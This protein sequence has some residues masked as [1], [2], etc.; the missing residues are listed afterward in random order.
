MAHVHAWDR[1]A[2]GV[3]EEG[4]AALLLACACGATHPRAIVDHEW[5]R[6]GR[7][8]AHARP[9][10]CACCSLELAA[11]LA[12]RCG[13]CRRWTPHKATIRRG[14]RPSGSPLTGLRL[15]C[16]PC[17][18]RADADREIPAKVSRAASLR[19]YHE[20]Q[21]EARRER[22]RVARAR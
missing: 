6:P 2:D 12:H 4:V 7:E 17:Q 13:V 15:S 22:R 18:R 16:L 11:Q 20:R 3:S 21:A 8:R 1:T 14:T 5:L 10:R 9:I 19:Y